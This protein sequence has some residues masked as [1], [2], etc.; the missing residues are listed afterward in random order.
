MLNLFQHLANPNLHQND[1]HGSHKESIEVQSLH[2]F[3]QFHKAAILMQLNR[4]IYSLHCL[5]LIT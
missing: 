3:T 4:H 5:A 2:A 1:N